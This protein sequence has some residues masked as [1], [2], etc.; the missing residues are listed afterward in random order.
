MPFICA[1]YLRTDALDRF[2]HR[3]SNPGDQSLTRRRARRYD[4]VA[5]FPYPNGAV[6]TRFLAQEAAVERIL[7]RTVPLK[8]R[9][10][11]PDSETMGAA[12]GASAGAVAQAATHLS[13]E[14]VLV[15]GEDERRRA[16]AELPPFAPIPA[17]RAFPVPTAR[18]TTARET[19]VSED[20]VE[21][22][23]ARAILRYTLHRAIAVSIWYAG[24]A[25]GIGLLTAL[26]AQH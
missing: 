18:T 8:P 9:P 21:S 15:L 7:P 14:L 1:K 16:I 23:L 24:I 13:P 10:P 4:R 11:L 25:V 26:L 5:G 20:A 2:R 3:K 6:L 19:N 12:I 22:P 17:R